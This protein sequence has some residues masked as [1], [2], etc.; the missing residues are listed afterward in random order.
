M[1]KDSNCHGSRFRRVD[2]K[3]RAGGV[4]GVDDVFPLARLPVGKIE[5]P[6]VDERRHSLNPLY[7]IVLTVATHD[8]A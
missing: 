8:C 3:K 1:A 6:R 2:D 5:I 7:F 4:L